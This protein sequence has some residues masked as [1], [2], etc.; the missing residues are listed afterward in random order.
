M[1]PLRLVSTDLDADPTAERVEL[2]L[3]EIPVLALWGMQ[4]GHSVHN[5]DLWS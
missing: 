4:E 3:E 5:D 1:A 2:V